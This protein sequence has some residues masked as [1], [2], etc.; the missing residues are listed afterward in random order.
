MRRLRRASTAR[1]RWNSP[2]SVLKQ[3][4]KLEDEG[5]RECPVCIAKTQYSFSDDAKLLGAPVGAH[6]A[7][8]ASAAER[9][10]GLCGGVRGGILSPCRGCRRFPPPK[11]LMW[12]KTAKLWACSDFFTLLCFKLRQSSVYLYCRG[13]RVC[14]RDQR[15]MKTD[16][17]LRSPLDPFAFAAHAAILYC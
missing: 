12:T 1:Q 14:G 6:A 3:L 13:F 9:G 16:E 10:R 2:G 5:W 15:A 7:H 4:Q 8:S 17:R 11:R